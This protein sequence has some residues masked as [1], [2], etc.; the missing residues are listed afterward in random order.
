MN[1]LLRIF[2]ALLLPIVFLS[3]NCSKTKKTQSRFSFVKTVVAEN[4]NEPMQIAEMPDGKIMLIERH[5]TI[6][7]YDPSTGL[8]NV[9]CEMTVVDSLED[10]L[11]GLAIDPEWEQNHWIYLYYSP[12]GKSYNQLSRFVFDNGTL[13]PA[14][15]KPLLQVHVQREQCC[16]SGGGLRFGDDGY[17]YLGTGDNTNPTDDYATV[18]ERPGRG[19]WDSQKSSSNTMDLRGKILRIKP[20]ADGSYI[21]PAGNLFAAED[22]QITNNEQQATTNGAFSGRPEIYVMGV[23]NPFRFSIDARR[24]VLY[25]G[26]VGPDASVNDSLRGPAGYDEINAARTAG[27]Y[28]WPYFI[29]DN[30]PYRD[31][32]HATQTPGPPFDPKHP[33]NDSPNNTG[34][35][36]LPPAQPA[37]IWYPYDPSPEFPVLDEYEG[38]GGR[39]AMAGPTYYADQYPPQTRL[40]DYYDGKLIIYDWMRNWMIAVTVDSAGQYVSM[41]PFAP[42]IPLTCPMDMLIDKNGVLWVLEYGTK[43]Y[44]ANP[45]ARLSR[46]EYVRGNRP[47]VPHLQADKFVGAAP[48]T[49]TFSAAK[50]FDWDEEELT[51]DIDFRDGSEPWVATVMNTANSDINNRQSAAVLENIVHVFEKTGTYNVRL[52]VQDESGRLASTTITIHVGN[53]PPM[54]QWDLGGKNRSFYEAGDVLDYKVVV[55]DRE[56]GSLETGSILPSAVVAA[57]DYLETGFDI[58]SIAHGQ[59]NDTTKTV[60][61]KGQ[62]LIE[63]SDCKTCHAQDK[64]VNGPAYLSIAERY[65]NDPSVVRKLA[66]KIIHGGGGSWGQTYMSTHPQL[67][68]AD[69]SEMVRWILSLGAAP[70]PK[71]SLPTEGSFT[72]SVPAAKGKNKQPNPGTFI[73]KASY[74]DRGSQS[75]TPLEARAM[76]A[77][78][79]AFQQA[80]QADSIS[81]GVSE[82]RP[83]GDDLLLLNNLKN[84][85]FFCF[86]H[87]DLTGI[88]SISLGI[89]LGDVQNQFIGGRVELHLGSPDGALIGQANILAKT[90]AGNMEFDEL[91][92]PVT[93]PADGQFHDVYFVFK[94]DN[95]AQGTVTAVDWVWFHIQLVDS[96]VHNNAPVR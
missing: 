26:D 68:E 15:E 80:E 74:R 48:L 31:F 39:N 2:F 67:S 93:A 89:G 11:M 21:C 96:S 22:V 75:Q 42:N 47:P 59:M 87:T 53:E 49:V 7:L 88:N 72:L 78:R 70:K 33:F 28:G 10:G 18:D 19:P 86:K 77:L 9:A 79:P 6:K 91:K 92:L 32:D 55:N 4:L 46:V 60:L 41:E 25:W 71:Q 43:R 66:Q 82:Y 35:R 56:D 83:F 3:Q 69:A 30:K 76:L 24:K 73:L 50:T 63:R 14:S 54:V 5:G 37:I 58:T 84:N 34:A 40:P 64:L 61:A 81:N 23:R 94:N 20:M 16:H 13:D 38:E 52:K 45:D 57:I 8:M 90:V 36:D 95:N 12:F 65:R 17:L 27:N 44:S 62:T 29:G 85:A 1:R 51:Y